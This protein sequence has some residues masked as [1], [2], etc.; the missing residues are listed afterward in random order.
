MRA[1]LVSLVVPLLTCAACEDDAGR[2]APPAPPPAVAPD[3]QA[4][5]D[6]VTAYLS[7]DPAGGRDYWCDPAGADAIAPRLADL[8][9]YRPN[10]SEALPD[11]AGS[12]SVSLQL[13]RADGEELT[14]LS[15]GS[16]TVRTPAGG[17]PDTP[18][19][20]S[21]AL[22]PPPLPIAL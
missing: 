2:E 13:L 4:A 8:A 10:V 6:L 19:I 9:P 3:P 16:A 22:Q 17:S 7:A 12:A 14:A 15:D 1:R 5:R 21:V 20:H 18:C 11:G